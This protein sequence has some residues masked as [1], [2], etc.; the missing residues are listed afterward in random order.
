MYN[1]III[2]TNVM[3]AFVL[4]L[5]YSEIGASLGPNSLSIYLKWLIILKALIQTSGDLRP[6]NTEKLEIK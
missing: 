1:F 2:L 5:I 6:K 3:W 4:Y